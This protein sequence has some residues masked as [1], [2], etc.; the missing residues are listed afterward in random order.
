M[1]TE[2]HSLLSTQLSTVNEM[3][4]SLGQ[5]INAAYMGKR[6]AAELQFRDTHND[7]RRDF[8]ETSKVIH[9]QIADCKQRLRS[10]LSHYIAQFT[11]LEQAIE[12]AAEVSEET[13]PT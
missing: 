9:T 6:L 3:E 4:T 10:A 1:F 7:Q 5:A 12:T 8:S 13:V 11:T 2:I